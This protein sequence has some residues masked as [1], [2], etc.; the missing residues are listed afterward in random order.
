MVNTAAY[1]K[2]KIESSGGKSL[3]SG[4]PEHLKRDNRWIN[5]EWINIKNGQVARQTR[6]EFVT[7]MR[8]DGW[9]VTLQNQPNEKI[10]GLLAKRKYNGFS[11]S[12]KR[13][14]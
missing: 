9:T 4:I 6:N 3:K 1:W 2:L 5:A 11:L 14:V 10:Y 7:L 8:D 12:T 13:S